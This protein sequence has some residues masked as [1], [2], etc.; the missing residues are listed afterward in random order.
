MFLIRV[1]FV[2]VSGLAS[3]MGAAA[4][5]AP[6]QPLT[7]VQTLAYCAQ[8][9]PK[10]LH[11]QQKPAAENLVIALC[12]GR[13]RFADGLRP[14][15]Q[16]PMGGQTRTLR[17]TLEKI[18]IFG[19]KLEPRSKADFADD[20]EVSVYKKV[21]TF[22]AFVGADALPIFAQMQAAFAAYTYWYNHITACR[23]IFEVA[24][25]LQAGDRSDAIVRQANYFNQGLHLPD[26]EAGVTTFVD[27]VGHLR[28]KYQKARAKQLEG[29]WGDGSAA[30][31]RYIPPVAL[32][33]LTASQRALAIVNIVGNT[34]NFDRRAA[35]AMLLP[36]A[37]S[38]TATP[39][40]LFNAVS[41]VNRPDILNDN[42]FFP[43]DQDGSFDF[44]LRTC[45]NGFV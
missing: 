2:M 43:M 26:S 24:S 44:S 36:F 22:A 32:L 17:S 3:V 4:P 33:T 42:N 11:E 8:Q 41:A 23:I 18:Q 19:C 37:S 16:V 15:A 27:F 29:K 39:Q 20:S 14:P 38:P 5:L 34:G 28:D 40:Q 1:F 7:G 35:E 10:L 25:R 21:L 13:L 45:L 30:P 31:E 9:L 12:S 6:S